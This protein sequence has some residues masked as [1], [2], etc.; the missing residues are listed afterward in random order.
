LQELPRIGVGGEFPR[1]LTPQQVGEKIR[2][3]YTAEWHPGN[4]GLVCKRRSLQVDRVASSRMSISFSGITSQRD[5][6]RAAS[7][8]GQRDTCCGSRRTTRSR[9][10]WL[11]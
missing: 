1:W 7:L 2:R 6:R 8:L 5:A 4:N 3:E 10:R 11:V 9:L